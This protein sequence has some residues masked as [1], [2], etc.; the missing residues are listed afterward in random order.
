ML[1]CQ[2]RALGVNAKSEE[3]SF[4]ISKPSFVRTERD[5]ILGTNLQENCEVIQ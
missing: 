1:K 2:M 4:R 5:V 3:L